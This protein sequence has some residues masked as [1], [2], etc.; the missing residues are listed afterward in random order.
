MADGE[1]QRIA[2]HEMGQ[3][4]GQQTLLLLLGEAGERPRGQADLRLADPEGQGH[5]HPGRAG[6]AN[7][8]A[9]LRAGRQLA[10]LGEH[11][12]A[13]HPW[14]RPQPVTDAGVRASV[15]PQQ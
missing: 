3:L 2:P 15:G 13:H 1:P 8:L 14:P 12:S 11:V 9:E 10:K 7:G 4:M 6:E 5:R